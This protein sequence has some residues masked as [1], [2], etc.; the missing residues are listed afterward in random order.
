MRKL[1]II[2]LI[3]LMQAMT[4]M[5]IDLS[6]LHFHPLQVEDG[7]S[8]NQVNAILKDSRG[9]LWF[10]TQSGLDRYDGFRFHNYF[11]DN[12]NP[13][14]LPNNS[15]DQIME[16]ADGT[17]WIHTSLGYCTYD[18]LTETFDPAPEKKLAGQGLAQR[19]NLLFFDKH[20]GMWAFVSGT[21][22]YYRAPTAERFILFSTQGRGARRLA[23]GEI[24]DIAQDGENIVV[25]YSG[26]RMVGIDVRQQRM[27]WQNDYVC[28]LYK[29]N[30]DGF[31]VFVDSRGSYWIS[32]ST[33]ST[34]VY[35]RKGHQWFDHAVDFLQH[36]GY[37]LSY[38]RLLL[39]QVCEDRQGRLWMATDHAG[40]IIY[41][42]AT[43]TFY[44]YSD[45]LPTQSPFP[46]N[47]IQSVYVDQMQNVWLGTY[48]NGVLAYSPTS[49]RFTTIHLGDVCSI[50]Q[51]RQGMLWCGTNESGIV[52]YDLR[53]GEQRTFS[54]AVTGLGTDVV[55]SSYCDRDGTVWFGTY[56]G[57]LAALRDGQWTV[58]RD[59]T[60]TLA[61]DN[62]W[63]ISGDR[64]GNII[65]G[66]LGG[67]LQ[68]LNPR[69]GQFTTYNTHNSALT[70]DYLNS[71]SQTPDG[72]I[73]IGHSMGFS[74]YDPK[75]HLIKSYDR[76]KDGTPFP[77]PSTNMAFMDSRGLIWLAS[78]TSLSFYDPR[79]G[80]QTNI[81]NR[82]ANHGFVGCSI[83]ED[84]LHQIWIV[85]DQRIG[86][87]QMTY[88][89]KKQEWD[90]TI[91]SYN[92]LDGLQKA[93]FNYRSICRLADDRIVVGGQ[94]GINI[95]TPQ[96]QTR[97]RGNVHAV[98]AGLTVFNELITAGKEF[99]GH[100]IL[101]RAIDQTQK[102][103]LRND[104]NT[105]T[106]LLAA[107]RFSVPERC[108]FLYR[109]RGS[110][111]QWIMTT[112]EQPAITFANLQPG[113]YHLDVKVVSA[114]GT[115]NDS[116]ST[117]E[118]VVRHPWYA[119]SLAYIIYI[120]LIIAAAFAYRRRI[121]RRQKELFRIQQMEADQ[122]N[123]QKLEEART[124]FFTN[125]SHELRTPLTLI[126]APIAKMIKT[127]TDGDK[128]ERLQLIH[129]NAQRLLM[130]VNQLLD[131]GK[132]ENHEM[133]L[134]AQQGELVS[135]ISNICKTFRELETKPIHLAF[136][137]NVESLI[138]PFD[139]DKM[140]K[141]ITNLLS[142]AYKFTPDGGHVDVTLAV[143]EDE[144]S[145]PAGNGEE[146]PSRIT[147]SV[148]D[149]GCGISDEDKKH[150]FDR[151]YQAMNGREK[152]NGTGVGLNL[153]KA[154]VD[155]MGA[156]LTVKDNE[157]GGTIF[158]VSLT[159][160]SSPSPSEGVDEEMLKSPTE[161]PQEPQICNPTSSPSVRL[162]ED[163][164]LGEASPLVLLVD[165]SADFRTFLK[166]ILTEQYRVVTAV[167]GVDALKTIVREK[168][169]LIL[170]DVMMP[171][172]DGIELCK[173]VKANPEM[174]GIPFVM[175]TA[176]LTEDQKM[177]GLSS[178][179]DDYITK[180]FN[181]DML[182]LRIANLLG[183][184][185]RGVDGKAVAEAQAEEA[186]EKFNVVD[187]E[188]MDKV[189]AYITEHLGEPTLTVEALSEAA[190][191]SRVYLYKRFVSLTGTTPSEYIR[192]MRLNK[193]KEY[194][195]Q[196]YN[197]SEVAYKVGFNNPRY[198]SKYFSEAFGMTP[199]EYRKRS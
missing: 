181:V 138:M 195:D 34:L 150:I 1:T 40:L 129:R 109:L 198:F 142:N 114:D 96:P 76:G 52:S 135:H 132:A 88:D 48:K 144:A 84:R 62:V 166:D 169:D 176:R 71:V 189:N 108:R 75:T 197:V 45:N 89:A 12:N 20:K 3:T 59:A 157:G 66:L 11:F 22:L 162:G 171:R 151:Y 82:D 19:P 15:V 41:D 133:K 77:S 7:L 163:S 93:Q 100:V 27:A 43:R 83:A 13:T 17:L 122:R 137:S 23:K 161:Q 121:L 187:K 63:S 61:S 102:L 196:G 193:S 73:I 130:L 38:G 85:S 94:D 136:H 69:T 179:A 127:E 111:N 2:L 68:V 55:V 153:V 21:G 128:K 123:R 124:N 50:T 47:T 53:T 92:Y 125:V 146:Q 113:D 16:D 148:A 39:K 165:D 4:A 54:K 116:V 155:L 5:A 65:L 172:M 120:V 14:A 190:S 98:F 99:R 87:V 18:H 8:N 29:N 107:D 143:S 37:T 159:Q 36:L 168:P 106:I 95:I 49:S 30:N 191:M 101:D 110:S 119:T 152:P 70:S 199:S 64:Y 104:E 51:D 42:P 6:N 175:L 188:F 46:A 160:L 117:M 170:S 139:G 112:P 58:Y 174:N 90:Y 149:T 192:S 194:L 158:T 32:S 141:I 35:H 26:G 86:K 79:T 164:L 33:H 180:P 183:W 147:I 28:R 31:H 156:D 126:I 74:I 140:T 115:I 186:R 91:T 25:T 9:F 57:G 178:G 103:V 67:G 167:D 60:S 24:C 173:R 97:R 131:M 145:S 184:H 72:R 185:S 81:D 44:N 118:I 134:N 10:G 78:A 80:Q 154:F 105:F 56:N 177:E 182:N